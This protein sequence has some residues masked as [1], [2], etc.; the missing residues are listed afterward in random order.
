MGKKA[1]WIK[2]AE[3]FEEGYDNL[4]PS[5][6]SEET[7]KLIGNKKILNPEDAQGENLY[8][9]ALGGVTNTGLL[10]FDGYV[11]AF[12]EQEAVDKLLD[13]MPHLGLDVN[14]LKSYSEDDISYGGNSGIPYL[15]EDLRELKLVKRAPRL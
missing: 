4:D 3:S 6:P 7:K 8:K 10:G 15:G 1:G 11:Y 5:V 14:D 13:K 12:N 2:K 9:V